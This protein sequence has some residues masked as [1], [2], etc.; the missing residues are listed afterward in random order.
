MEPGGLAKAGSMQWAGDIQNVG[1]RSLSEV[2][3]T[4]ESVSGA[5]RQKRMTPWRC[6]NQRGVEDRDCQGLLCLFCALRI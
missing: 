5:E 1:V 6:Q 4:E 2:S 3:V